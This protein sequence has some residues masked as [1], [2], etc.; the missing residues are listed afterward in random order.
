MSSYTGLDT[1]SRYSQFQHMEEDG[2]LGLIKNVPT[3]PEGFDLFLSQL[4]DP[5]IITFEAGRNYWWLHELL[6]NH[7]KVSDVCVVD[8]RRS[9]KIASELSVISGYGRAK[10]DRIDSEM[11]AEQTRRGLAPRIYVPSSEQLE[12]RTVQRFR[13]VS[14]NCQ[15][16]AKN[17]IHAILAHHGKSLSIKQLMTEADARKQ[18]YESLPIYVQLILNQLQNRIQMIEMQIDTLENELNR[19]LPE[20]APLMKLII[21]IPGFGPIT[22]RIVITEILDIKYFAKP[23]NLISYSG[24]APLVNESANRKGPEKLNRYSN[25]FLKYAF[26]QAA[27]NAADNPRFQKKYE[28]DIKKHDKI[29]AKLNLARRLAKTVYWILTRQQPFK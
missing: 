29:I 16:Q 21:S 17:T 11:L 12:V 1:H 20:S 25:H 28:S 4:D 8:P 3:T 5:T 22:A 2:T 26:V 9:R 19:I 13:S 23:E 27:H 7:P 18:L 15:T 10:N 24:L 14:V 6:K